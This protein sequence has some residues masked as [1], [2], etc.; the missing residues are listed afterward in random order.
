MS[1]LVLGINHKTAPVTIREK[2]AFSTEHL[3]YAL[4]NLHQQ[5]N[6]EE[7]V[8]VS[9]CNRTEIY[10]LMLQNQPNIIKKWLADFHKISLQDIDP[11]LYYYNKHDTIQHIMR[12]SSGLDSLVLGEPQILGQMKTAFQ[13]AK[14]A[15]TIGKYLRKLFEFSFS[16]AKQ[17]RTDTSI[18]S[19]PVSVAF[20]AVSLAKQ[21][22]G[23]LSQ[24]TILLIGAGET[25]E[26]VAQHLYEQEV[27]Q[28]IVAN[29]TVTK[30]WGL[31]KQ[32]QAASIPLT[33]IPKHLNKADIIISSTG[34][35]LP[36]LSK[37]DIKASLKQRKH[38]PIFIVDL[39]VPSDIEAS[40]AELADVYLYTVDDL[41]EIIQ[42]NLAS[43]QQ[44][45]EQAEEI[46][47]TQTQHFIYWL[48]SQNA[49]ELV[50]QYRQQAEQYRDQAINQALRQLHNGHSAE[51]VIQT[52]AYQLT[53]KIIHTPTTKL[54]QAAR[55]E[56]TELLQAACLL[57]ELQQAKQK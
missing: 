36:I 17:I 25:I 28:M 44:A 14:Q 6:I 19:S 16:V 10:C 54:K 18:G 46:V 26:L 42:E 9:T 7:N 40:T 43:R 56:Q 5:P 33:D 12:V 30:A 41:Q 2:L 22:F 45:A 57:L 38:Q 52:L 31:A 21:I 34:S 13:Q 15:K 37:A 8:I 1:F 20:A 50:C 4:E 11:Y 47:T 39:A 53:N 32:Y 23:D 55:Q 49:I 48:R 3:H 51:Q 35:P 29:R 24:Q 27:K